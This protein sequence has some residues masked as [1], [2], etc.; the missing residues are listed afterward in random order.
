MATVMM[1]FA[2]GAVALTGGLAAAAFVKAFGTGFLALPRSPGAESAVEVGFAMRSGMVILAAACVGLGVVPGL[3]L[4]PL[5][6]SVQALH[7]LANGPGVEVI[8]VGI[9]TAG[10]AGRLAPGVIAV[11]LAAALAVLLTVGWLVRV[12]RHRRPVEAWGCGRT[13]RT[14]RMEYTATSFAEPLQRVFDDVLRPELDLD[15]SH[16]SESRYYL[17]AVR[18]RMGIS[19]AFESRVYRPLVEGFRRLG[20][21]ARAVQN[22]SIHLYLGYML[23]VVLAVLLVS[24]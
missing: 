22:G 21:R 14:A 8:G 19:D 5:Q 11:T 3:V 17:E 10:S 6:R 4:A 20:E 16:T 24:R 13:V 15:V 9:E 18:Y 12:R 2:V 23:V 7:G 1:P